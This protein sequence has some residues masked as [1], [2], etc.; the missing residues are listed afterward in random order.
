MKADIYLTLIPVHICIW[1][2]D[3]SSFDV[4]VLCRTERKGKGGWGSVKACKRR[5]MKQHEEKRG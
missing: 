2:D 3:K 4:F 1:N 5:Y